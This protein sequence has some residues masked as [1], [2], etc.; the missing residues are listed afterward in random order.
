MFSCSFSLKQKQNKNTTKNN[1]RNKRKT[2]N[3]LYVCDWSRAFLA[4][5]IYALLFTR[6]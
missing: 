3:K 2:N 6:T 4:I 5:F 1:K